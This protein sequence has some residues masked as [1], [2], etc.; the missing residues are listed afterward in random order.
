MRISVGFDGGGAFFGNRYAVEPLLL[1][2]PFAVSVLVPWT[3]RSRRRRALAVAAGG[4]GVALHAFAEVLS[5][6]L[7]GL[8]TASPWVTWYPLYIGRA[9]GASGA[10]AACSLLMALAVATALALRPDQDEAEDEDGGAAEVMA[11]LPAAAAEAFFASP[12]VPA[13][14]SGASASTRR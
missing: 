7:I 2:T 13:P 4:L 5:W 11:P 8:G 14:R 12:A 9:A 10:I 1:A 6:A 3:A